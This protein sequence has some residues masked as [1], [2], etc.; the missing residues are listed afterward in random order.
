LC[1]FLNFSCFLSFSFPFDWIL[2]PKIEKCIE[3]DFIDLFDSSNYIEK[4]SSSFTPLLDEDWNEENENN[5]KIYHSIYK[6]TFLHDT[7][8][9]LIEKYKRRVDRF[10]K[11]MKDPII[12]KKLFRMSKDISE[13]SIL[14]DKKG[15]VNYKI[16]YQKMISGQDWKK[17]EFDWK[18]WFN[19]C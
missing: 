13:L 10:Y 16:Y 5:I 3:N 1:C 7:F 9:D 2:S 15:F 18:K 19:Y 12:H 8:T 6:L 14:F 4:N 11:I 17:E